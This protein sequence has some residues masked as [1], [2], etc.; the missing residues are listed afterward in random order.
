MLKRAIVIGCLLCIFAG[1]L[2]A[3]FWFFVEAPLI[4]AV[5]QGDSNAVDR[6]LTAGV[7]VNQAGHKQQTALHAAMLRGDKEIFSRLL[8][9]GADPNHCDYRGS[10]IMHL[11]AREE[12]SFWLR[13]ALRNGGNPN[14]P[15]TG[16]RPYP[17]S[18]PIFYAIDGRCFQ[19]VLELIKNGADV[20]HK[21][22]KGY[23]PFWKAFG[24][25]RF[26]IASELIKA[27]AD[28]MAHSEYY[29]LQSLNS[30]FESHLGDDEKKPYHELIN[31]L[32]EAGYLSPEKP[33]KP[34]K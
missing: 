10:S 33:H 19:N 11:A 3:Y 18:T 14:Q 32:I 24:E 2:S 13:E 23:V 25:R 15:N 26:A 8:S 5:K 17:N 22:S 6:M 16:N 7:D 29:D 31:S 30:A 1:V 28:P 20:N 12:D 21:N 4:R 27:G 34:L 9:S